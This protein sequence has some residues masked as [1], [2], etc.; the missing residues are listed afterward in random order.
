ML[1]WE[2]VNFYFIFDLLD[3]MNTQNAGAVGAPQVRTVNW[4]D[5][6]GHNEIKK[7]IVRSLMTADFGSGLRRSGILYIY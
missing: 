1:S 3:R 6:A 5:V 7:K 4:T 2:K